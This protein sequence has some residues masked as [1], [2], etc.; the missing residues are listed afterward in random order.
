M[1]HRDAHPGIKRMLQ[2]RDYS[3]VPASNDEIIS[4][5]TQ[6]PD[7]KHQDSSQGNSS[8]PSALPSHKHLNI[9]LPNDSGWS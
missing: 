3:G 2:L 8:R 5:R 4:Q 9:S 1:I 6:V 7:F